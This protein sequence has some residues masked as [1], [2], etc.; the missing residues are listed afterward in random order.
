MQLWG[1]FGNYDGHGEDS[2]D[3]KIVSHEPCVSLKAIS[4]TQLVD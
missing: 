4:I 2:V 3:W 1:S